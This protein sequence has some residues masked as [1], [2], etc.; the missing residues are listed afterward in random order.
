MATEGC[1]QQS[2]GLI[3]GRE[4]D[5]LQ[6][7][8]SLSVALTWVTW[9]M[10]HPLLGLYSV[11]QMKRIRW[12]PRSFL[13]LK[14]HDVWWFEFNWL[15]SRLLCTSAQPEL[16]LLSLSDSDKLQSHIEGSFLSSI[17]E[18]YLALLLGVTQFNSHLIQC[19]LNTYFSQI[20]KE[21]PGFPGEPWEAW[22]FST[23]SPSI[24]KQL[25]IVYGSLDIEH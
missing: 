21:S 24:S 5:W 2:N 13:A 25:L 22:W 7:V 8:P 1:I 17:S 9:G 11:K 15:F 6:S 12:S 19:W 10:L 20:I 18:T 3:Y 14:L 23:F 4:R 16:S